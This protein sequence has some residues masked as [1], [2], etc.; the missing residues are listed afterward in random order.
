M[1]RLGEVASRPWVWGLCVEVVFQLPLLKICV[2]H[3]GYGDCVFE[4]F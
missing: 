1:Y 3:V 2:L 4:E